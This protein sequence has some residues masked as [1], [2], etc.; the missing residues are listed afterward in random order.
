[1]RVTVPESS[2]ASRDSVISVVIK[3]NKSLSG[4]VDNLKKSSRLEIQFPDCIRTWEFQHFFPQKA[5]QI[6]EYKLYTHLHGFT[7]LKFYVNAYKNL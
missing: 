7:L 1:M 2:A 4:M 6:F 3:A 5:I